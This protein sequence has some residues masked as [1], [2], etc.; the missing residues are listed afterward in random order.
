MKLETLYGPN[1]V[2]SMAEK[3]FFTKPVPLACD[4][5]KI[6]MLRLNYNVSVLT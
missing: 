5:H 6:Q 1:P 3:M 2:C 4:T